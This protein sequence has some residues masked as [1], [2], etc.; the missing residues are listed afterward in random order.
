MDICKNNTH[1]DTNTTQI[2]HGT[3]ELTHNY[4][5]NVLPHLSFRFKVAGGPTNSNLPTKPC[6]LTPKA[7]LGPKRIDQ[8][9]MT[10]MKHKHK[11]HGDH[12]H[13]SMV[14]IQI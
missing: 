8:H 6:V 1:Y 10:F 7:R 4:I 9:K 5:L 11:T 14:Q 12:D 3:H 13:G 2:H